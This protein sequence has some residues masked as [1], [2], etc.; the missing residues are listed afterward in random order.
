MSESENEP[1]N[2]EIDTEKP[3]ETVQITEIET[4]PKKVKKPRS[5]A[6]KKAFEKAVAT[7]RANQKRQADAR[8]AKKEVKPQVADRSS[9]EEEEVVVKRRS[10]KKKPRRRI[11]YEDSSSSEEETVAVVKRRKKKKK[12][13][14]L[15]ESD[16]EEAD[17][18]APAP[19]PAPVYVPRMPQFQLV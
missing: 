9:D 5:D 15:Y 1:E 8:K 11:V 4:K 7:R 13:E 6:Q 2:V 18:P 12:P 19:A 10:K 16:I 3:T 14:V 17:E